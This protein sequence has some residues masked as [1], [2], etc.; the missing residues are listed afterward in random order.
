MLK[1]S[2]KERLSLPFRIAHG[3]LGNSRWVGI[4]LVMP[5]PCYV[6]FLRYIR[7]LSAITG[8][9]GRCGTDLKSYRYR[10]G[11]AN[12]AGGPCHRIGVAKPEFRYTLKPNF[13]RD[14]HFQP[15]EV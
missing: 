8:T 6:Q 15:C 3:V 10:A 7:L 4:S 1:H 12:L 2:R 11:T 5:G 14:L 9:S 13:D